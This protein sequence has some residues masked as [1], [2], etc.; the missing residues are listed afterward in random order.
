[1][2]LHHQRMELH[3]QQ[4]ELHHQQMEL[5]YQ[6]MELHHQQIEL[7]HQQMELY[8]QQMEQTTPGAKS[9][10]YRICLPQGANF[11]KS[12]V[13]FSSWQQGQEGPF[14]EAQRWGSLYGS[15]NNNLIKYT[16]NG[17]NNPS[18]GTGIR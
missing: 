8:H 6:Q 14:A 1:M 9:G 3:H 15:R 4:M 12:R 2:E 13:R 16:I 5:P 18:R 10:G 11:S 17:Q 7:H